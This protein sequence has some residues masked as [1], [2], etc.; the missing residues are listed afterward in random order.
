MRFEPRDLRRNDTT[1]HVVPV[2]NHLG[3]IVHVVISNTV[4]PPMLRRELRELQDGRVILASVS[5]EP[6]FER[7]HYS[8]LEN[9]YAQDPDGKGT[10]RFAAYLEPMAY[11][12]ECEKVGQVPDPFPKEL[13]PQ[14]VLKRQNGDGPARNSWTPKVEA[15]APT[16][17]ASPA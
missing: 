2:V 16:V 11:G 10:Q 8:L 7:N 15:I 9:D 14:S 6:A 13:L 1:P 5:L 4:D 3:C 17:E 12:A